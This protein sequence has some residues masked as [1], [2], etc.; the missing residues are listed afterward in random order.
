MVAQQEPQPISFAQ[1]LPQLPA[2]TT[3]L[4]TAQLAQLYTY[5]APHNS[6]VF[7]RA[8]MV[9]T[10]DGA[11][12]GANGLSGGINNAADYVVFQILRA[13]AQVVLV[14][15]GTARSEGYRHIKAPAI[16]Q[17]LRAAHGITAPLEFA[18]ISRSGVLPANLL[19]QGPGL[20][21]P[22]VFTTTQGSEQLLQNHAQPRVIVAER[23]GEVH[24]GEVLQ[25][26]AALGLTKVLTEGGPSL[27]AQFIAQDLLDELC[28]TTVNIIQPGSSLGITSH[29]ELDHHGHPA[30]LS[31]LLYADKTLL[32]RWGLN[33]QTV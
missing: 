33:R 1:L 3:G 5:P 26:L 8:N 32:A 14:G 4:T 12:T 21:Q 10:V 17:E 6:P 27:L 11:A 31:S 13:L 9:S 30:E 18:V 20:P 15:A 22:I 24:L 19:D 7:L 2:Q 29:P 28:L 23:D 16:H 25:N